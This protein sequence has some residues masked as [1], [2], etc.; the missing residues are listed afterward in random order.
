MRL[1]CDNVIKAYSMGLGSEGAQSQAWANQEKHFLNLIFV[2]LL[3]FFLSCSLNTTHP[4]VGAESECV[5]FS[6][7]A[8][9]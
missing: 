7:L 4:F 1:T 9:S 3:V 8:K 2:F 5:S 6:V